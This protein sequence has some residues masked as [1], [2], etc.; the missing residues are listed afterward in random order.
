MSHKPA[1][2]IQQ[3]IQDL[4]NVRK[5]RL[6]VLPWGISKVTQEKKEREIILPPKPNY[7]TMEEWRKAH[8]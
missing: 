3:Q 6:P 4:I 2:P 1:K 8:E 5:A 7:Y